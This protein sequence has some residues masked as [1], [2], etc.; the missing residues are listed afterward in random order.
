MRNGREGGWK[1][2][3]RGGRW[4]IGKRGGKS[5]RNGKGTVEGRLEG[6]KKVD[7]R[8]GTEVRVR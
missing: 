5:V 1:G 2:G 8:G 7:R 3:C 4:I 6:G